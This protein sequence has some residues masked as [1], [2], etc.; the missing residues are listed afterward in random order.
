MVESNQHPYL[1]HIVFPLD[2]IDFE[3]LDPYLELL[4]R[5]PHKHGVVFMSSKPGE[6][7]HR[8][9]TSF[10][11][12]KAAGGLVVDTAG[13]VLLIHRNG[14]WD[15]P[16]GKVDKGEFLR[17]AAMRE[18]KEECGVQEL[19]IVSTIKPTFHIYDLEGQRIL[20]TTFW[21]L[22][23]CAD[24]ERAHPQVEEGIDEVRWVEQSDLG[25][26]IEGSY[27]NIKLL[28]ALF[29]SKRRE[30]GGPDQ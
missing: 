8:F 26:Y 29:I 6:L 15:L 18:V 19:R 2:A 3:G 22:M 5:H 16:K 25:P 14:M 30:Y 10:T 13:K 24:P 21:Y 17:Q 7:F 20:K 12:V 1:D 23:D 28:L 27:S 11:E 9:C 4:S